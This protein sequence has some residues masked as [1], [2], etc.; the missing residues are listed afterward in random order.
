MDRIR[1]PFSGS[2][3]VARRL[4]VTIALAA[5]ALVAALAACSFYVVWFRTH[6]D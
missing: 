4:A 3:G 5:G 6:S 2:D 1:I